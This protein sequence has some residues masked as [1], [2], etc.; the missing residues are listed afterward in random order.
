MIRLYVNSNSVD[1]TIDLYLY[2]FI[3]VCRHRDVFD[4]SHPA[5]RFDPSLA[6]RDIVAVRY[7]GVA[8]RTANIPVDYL[9][10]KNP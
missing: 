7:S 9:M 1:Y 2:L 5:G 10:P 6:A 3:A 8:N 4:I